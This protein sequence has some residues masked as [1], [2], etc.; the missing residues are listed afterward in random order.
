M[1]IE[2]TTPDPG[3]DA[4]RLVVLAQAARALHGERDLERALA[5]ART[6]AKE[7]TG[8]PEAAICLLPRHG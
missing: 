8:M 5:W 1:A 2:R 6:A 7:L 3:L 4:G